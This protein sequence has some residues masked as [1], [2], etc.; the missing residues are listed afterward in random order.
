MN[1]VLLHCWREWRAQRA[2]LVAYAALGLGCLCLA[3]L[4][5]P[6]GFWEREGQAAFALSW[7]AVV[8]V[9]GVAAFAAPALV[10]G[11]YGTKDDQFV[12]RLP[13]ALRPAFGGKLLFLLL[14]AAGLPLL[15]LLAGEGLL[16]AIGRPWHD[17]FRWQWDGSVY[18]AWPWPAYVAA[19]TL[20]LA[21]WVWAIGTWLPGGRMAVGGALLVMLL[22]GLAVFV[23]LRHSPGL[24]RTLDGTGWLWAVW[25]AGLVVA[26]WSWVRGR[27]GGGPLRS[28][29]CGL[30]AAAVVL[31]PPA[32]WFGTH[33]AGYHFPDPY[34]LAELRVQGL[35]PDGRFAL[36]AGTADHRFAHVCFRLDLATGA[37]ERIAGAAAHLSP[38]LLPPLAPQWTAVQQH[39]LLQQGGGSGHRLLDLATGAQNALAVDARHDP[40]LPAALQA[41]LAAGRRAHTPLRA[42]G[43]RPVWFDGD[44]LCIG[45]ADGGIDRRPSPLPA[46]TWSYAAGHGFQAPHAAGMQVF[47][48]RG[49]RLELPKD[50]RDVFVVRDR[51]LFL[52]GVPHQRGSVPRGWYT[53]PVDGGAPE[54]LAPL[55]RARVLGL[56]D[57]DRVLCVA[58]ARP[59]QVR[60]GLFLLTP[61]TGQV[62]DLALPA[63]VPFRSVGVLYPLGAPGSLLPRDPAGCIWLRAFDPERSVVLRVDAAGASS[64][65]QPERAAAA[66]FDLQLLGWADAGT[67]LVRAGTSI[68]RLDPGTGDTTLLFPRP[69]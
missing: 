58:E 24:D 11:E 49:D 47:T 14:V 33:V 44:R 7:F 59:D 64:V 20:L 13:G 22:L 19:G 45:R 10:R 67:A 37:A 31:A 48:W 42:P 18:V 35:S 50:A 39:W 4:L 5:L 1:L 25:P 34:A 3:F 46:R 12:R 69:R 17:L 8:G 60:P 23:A 32:S 63:Q 30:V 52:R 54:P 15:L 68:L 53:Q 61:A 43:G 16:L 56:F 26:G 62:Q 9:V 66:G 2:V 40:V 36:V 6:D 51:V 38:S 21:P 55:S 41:S 29:R 28:A 27:R 65:P 57:D